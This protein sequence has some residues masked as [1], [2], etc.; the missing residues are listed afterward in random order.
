MRTARVLLLRL[1]SLFRQAKVDREFEAELK[2]HFEQ[3]VGENLAKGM[4][5]A[6]ARR[7]AA[8]A[9]SGLAR[10][11]EEC[12]DARRVMPLIDFARDCRYAGR[13]LVKNRV[14]A[15]VAIATLALGIG[16][17][18]A[19]FSVVNGVLLQPLPYPDAQRIVS[20]GTRSTDSG[21]ETSRLTGGDLIDLRGGTDCF[22]A[23]SAYWGGEIGVQV[24]GRGEFAGVF[25]VEPSFFRVFSVTPSKG[26]TFTTL[27][28][29]EA[30]VIGSGLAVRVFGSPARALGKT[31]SVEGRAYEIVGVLPAGFTA[32]QATDLWLPMPEV[33]AVALNRT[34]FNFR[35]VARLAP[36]L[37][38]KEAQTRV[39]AL[40][41]RLAR[42][43]PASNGART[44]SITPL[45]DRLVASTRLTLW[46]LLGAVLL[47]LLIACVNVAN[48]LL[49]RSTTRAHE[50]ALRASLGATR[51]RILRQLA[52]ES[53][54]LAAIGG[55]L[56]L[57]L[58]YAGTGA[59]LRLAPDTLPRLDEVAVD[60]RALAFAGVLSLLASLIFGL[61]P[62]W[63]ASRAAPHDGLRQ[64]GRTMLSGR[65]TRLR[66]LL[67]VGEIAL[68]FALA[69]GGGLLFRSFV[70]LTRADLGYRQDSVLVVTAHRPAKGEQ[71]YVRV[72]RFFSEIG[73]SLS[74]VPGV[75]AV[76]A[77]MGLPTGQYGSNGSYWVEGKHG[78]DAPQLPEAGF[79][80]ASPGYFAALGVPLVGGRDFNDGD[81][82]DAPFVAVISQALA[83][84]TFRGEDPIGRRL[85]CGLD[86]PDKWMTIVGVVGDVRQESPASSPEPQL[87]MPLE[88][89]P[90]HAN[91]VHVVLRTSVPPTSLVP[92]VGELMHRLTPETALKFT[93]LDEMVGASIGTPRFR[94]LL[95]GMFAALALLLSV[96]GIYGVTSYLTAQRAGEFG[97]RIALGAQRAD[98]FRLVLGGAARLAVSGL[99]LG[100]ALSLAVGRLI[101]SLLFGLEPLDPVTYPAT[102]ALVLVVVLTA[103]AVPAAGAAR[104]DPMNALR[105]E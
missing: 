104:V 29:A 58:A 99:L 2:F 49:A 43:F 67:V 12:R 52:T 97:L 79:R 8:R 19:I 16:A 105:R 21:R 51:W 26:R 13:M 6:E 42:A 57:L 44:F 3:Q 60:W 7:E 24:A 39:T 10:V 53:L 38:P 98:V 9:M 93:T 5:A 48:L 15:G 62:A 78:A 17:T 95:V 68:S 89:H 36:G 34:A 96:A 4:T 69:I 25:W 76:G 86:A 82:F 55:V 94:T 40:G 22:D 46:V 33:P 91:E 100:L 14:F 28:D 54:L 65:S 59:L 1:R 11:A 75:K 32:P 56:G 87:Y 31:V 20:L 37:S 73:P 64:G 77:T 71:E 90:Y 70:T 50:M 23:F 61:A 63:Q 83:R 101:A 85:R 102:L 72:A 45:R 18:T 74:A 80:L 41:T 35:A 88:Q 66:R 92:T 81:R 103:A 84:Q 27:A 30:A 47:V